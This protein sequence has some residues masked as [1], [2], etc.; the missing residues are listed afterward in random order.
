MAGSYR[1][2]VDDDG[3]LHT[4]EGMLIATETQGDA[5]ETI[6]EMYGMIWYLANGD[7]DLVEEARV[8]WQVGIERSPGRREAP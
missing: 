3:K 1:H 8:N 2:A 6:E 7:A 4:G 5:Y